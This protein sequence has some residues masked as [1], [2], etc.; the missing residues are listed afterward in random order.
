M[1]IHV[2]LIYCFTDT[3]HLYSHSKS[4]AKN[5]LQKSDVRVRWWPAPPAYVATYLLNY[6]IINFNRLIIIQWNYSGGEAEYND[7]EDRRNKKYHGY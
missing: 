6:L 2:I 4:Y 7:Y 3:V 5:C 1:Y